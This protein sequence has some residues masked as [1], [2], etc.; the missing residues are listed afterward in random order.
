ML[1]KLMK[2]D[3]KNMGKLLLPLNVIVLLMSL[4]GSI[5]R[6]SG[7]FDLE[8]ATPLF[9]ILLVTYIIGM[10]VIAVVAFFYPIIYFYRHLFSRQG[11]LTFTLP[12]C[13]WK[14]LF[15]KTIVGYCWYLINIGVALF[16]IWAITGFLRIPEMHLT[17]LNLYSREYIGMSF[18]AF[19]WW[20]VALTIFSLFYTL[21]SAYVSIAIGQLWS[22]HKIVGSIVAYLVIYTIVQILV[23]FTILPFLFGGF[24]VGRMVL[25]SF[26]ASIIIGVILS[27]I[28]YITSGI[29]LKK[30]V[31][32]D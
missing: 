21:L 17:N 30:K 6:V 28:F 24:D 27:V 4:V 26:Y 5:L 7:L 25:V 8:N 11:Y 20:A 18:T 13:S 31:N 14:I 9:G 23:T 1:G 3:I 15:S 16:S 10:A 2:H 32:L 22:K 19:M 12:V 29:I